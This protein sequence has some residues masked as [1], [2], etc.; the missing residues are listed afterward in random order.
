MSFTPCSTALSGNIAGD[1]NN[2]RIKG[3]NQVGLIFKKSDIDLA[4]TTVSGTNGRIIDNLAIKAG[5]VVSAIYNKKQNPLPFG[6][7]KTTFNREADAYD[8]IV[9]FYFEGIG[10]EKAKG[11]VEPL[12]DG[13][14]VV[15]LHRKDT[16]GDGSFQ[17][18]GYQVGLSCANNGGAQAQD[19]ETG[20]WLITMA[21][22]EP[23]AEVSLFDTDYE[24]TLTAFNALQALTVS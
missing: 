12:K 14:Y 9:Q 19:E 20:Y 2:P 11:V 21:T 23:F 22:Q 10:G 13:E 18:F 5:G 4:L 24:T 15:L 3:Y 17:L 6:G 16:R 8:K 7:T 1:C